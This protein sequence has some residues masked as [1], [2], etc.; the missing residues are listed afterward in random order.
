MQPLALG[1]IIPAAD[2]IARLERVQ[3][4]GFPT[5]QL[6]CVGGRFLVNCTADELRA[7]MM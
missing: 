1:L 2:P 3:S 7:A 4:R 5:C 6:S